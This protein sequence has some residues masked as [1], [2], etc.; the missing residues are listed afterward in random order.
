MRQ[1]SI[2]RRLVSLTAVGFLAISL[3]ACA[4]SIPILAGKSAE[5]TESQSSEQ[6]SEQGGTPDSATPDTA[7]SEPVAEIVEEGIDG[8]WC[9]TRE[10]AGAECV[11]VSFGSVYHE[12]GGAD[13]LVGPHA[14]P[15]GTESYSVPGAPFGTFYPAG[16]PVDI[17]EYY[18][19]SDIIDQDR[20]WNSQSGV[21]LLR[22]AQ[23]STV[24][25][26]AQ[27]Q[28]DWCSTDAARECFSLATTLVANPDAFVQSVSRS[29]FID[30]ATEISL[31]L[32]ADIGPESCS[33]AASMFFRFF[34]E[35]VE[36]DCGK[37]ASEGALPYGFTACSPDYTLAHDVFKD[38]L[39]RVP[40]H[41]HDAAYTDSVPMY[42]V[43]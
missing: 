13:E 6:V 15:D 19:G 18:A 31:C 5:P 28:G 23:P 3:S 10:S 39:I 14:M 24:N 27:L 21:M 7:T 40:N 38:R 30:G 33:T 17:P 9:P 41:Q 20:I 8:R 1:N 42:S 22:E 34:P 25:F 37:L 29:D 36:W 35:G 2:L 4:N 16:T 12:A 43:G 11:A 26:P 32:V